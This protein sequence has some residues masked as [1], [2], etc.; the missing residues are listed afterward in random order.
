MYQGKIH[1]HDF[2]EP[3]S[4]VV[5]EKDRHLCSDGENDQCCWGEEALNRKDS[6]TGFVIMYAGCPI[7]WG[8]KLQM[9]I[10]LSTTKAEYIVHFI[11]QCHESF[12]RDHATWVPHTWLN[13]KDVCQ[14]FEDNRNCIEIVTNHKTR[15]RTKH[16]LVRL[17]HFHTH[18]VNKMITINHIQMEQ[19]G[20]M[21]MKPLAKGTLRN[22]LMRWTS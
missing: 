10:A 2:I 1:Q 6:R 22:K 12:D 5:S 3:R 18:V 11:Y 13:S 15:A 9:L 4:V 17:H 8:S 21:F 19:L 14:L 7:I 20:D 16:L